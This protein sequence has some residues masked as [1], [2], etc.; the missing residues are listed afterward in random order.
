MCG[1]VAAAQGYR[2]IVDMLVTNG[3][4][5]TTPPQVRDCAYRLREVAVFPDDTPSIVPI[6]QACDVKCEAGLYRSSI[7]TVCFASLG[8]NDAVTATEL[9][10]HA[11]G[12][13]PSDTGGRITELPTAVSSPSAAFTAGAGAAGAGSGNGAGCGSP[14][15]M[16]TSA[17]VVQRF[18]GPTLIP[19]L[20]A[21]Q[22]SLRAPLAVM[23]G[24]AA[25]MAQLI[26]DG[27]L[28]GVTYDVEANVAIV[29]LQV[30]CS[31]WPPSVDDIQSVVPSKMQ[32]EEAEH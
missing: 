26:E 15:E 5:I 17:S 12:A 21:Q 13:R 28:Q 19:H 24:V 1:D 11:A 7:G 18:T 9:N 31:E 3:A 32:A 29:L 27:R 2:D 25:L 6:V 22:V 16:P 20:L 8:F 4:I 23:G 10:S 30:E 14:A